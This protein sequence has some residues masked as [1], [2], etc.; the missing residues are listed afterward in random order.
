MGIACPRCRLFLLGPE[1]SPGGQF[2]QIKRGYDNASD[3]TDWSTTGVTTIGLRKSLSCFAC[4]HG[5]RSIGRQ[6]PNSKFCAQWPVALVPD[7]TTS[8]CPRPCSRFTSDTSR[9]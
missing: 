8:F 2:L 1:R 4:P 7:S 9:I 6:L 5:V 3:M